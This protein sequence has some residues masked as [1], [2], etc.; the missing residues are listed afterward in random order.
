MMSGRQA[1]DR[2]IVHHLIVGA[3]QE[4]RIDRDE[5]FQAFG[6]KAGGESRH[7]VRQCRRRTCVR[8]GLVEDVD[9]GAGRH[10][11]SDRDDLV[12]FSASFTRLLPN[13]LV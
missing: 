13:T 9:T 2:D 10:R 12:V 11:R 1:L 6:G 5:R 8:E 7:A 4:G 3:L